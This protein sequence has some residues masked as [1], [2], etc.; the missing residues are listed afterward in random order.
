[1]CAA[2][3][4]CAAQ[5]TVGRRG[6]RARDRG[7]ATASA[8]DAALGRAAGGGE[9]GAA[10]AP[11]TEP[12]AV[13]A[14]PPDGDPVA[15]AGGDRPSNGGIG[16]LVY[17]RVP[18]ATAVRHW[19]SHVQPSSR[20]LRPPLWPSSSRR[21]WPSRR[22]ACCPPPARA[23]PARA[24]PIRSTS[25]GCAPTSRSSPR[26]SS[27]AATRRRAASTWR[28]A[29]WPPALQALGL[30][31]AG[32]DGGYFQRFGTTRRTVDPAK[33]TVTLGDRTFA[34]RRRLPGHGAGHRRGAAG[35]RRPR[36]RREEEGHRRLWRR[37]RE[38]QDPRRP[39]RAIRRASPAPTCAASPGPTRG[40]ARPA[41]PPGTAPSA[42]CSCPTT[43]R[44]P[45]GAPAATT[46]PRRA[47]S[48]TVDA[49]QAGR[50][51]PVPVI[52]ASMPLVSAI[53]SG[54]SISASD[55]AKWAQEHKAHAV[56]ALDEK[57][58][59]R[60]D[61]GAR[62]EAVHD[63]ERR[64]HLRGRRPGAQAGV[65]RARRPLRPHR[66][67]DVRHRPHQQ[68]RR[69]RRLG[70]RRAAE[71]RR[72]AGPRQRADEAVVAVR[73]ARRRRDGA[74]GARATSSS[75]RPCRSTR[76]SSQLNVDMIGRSR[77]PGDPAAPTTRSPA[78][79]RST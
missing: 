23:P 5:S 63:A 29:T 22:P 78:R 21:A 56:V 32:D 12:G 8:T 79:T 30:K 4:P 35:L 68:R 49:F 38:G 54:E 65:R 37:R 58:R 7:A 66:R 69:R 25:A 62:I 24:A 16:P 70:H 31:P 73:L 55:V 67:V 61:L 2:L 20:R 13:P 26:T 10:R 34:L 11:V 44:W 47:A 18:A 27:K 50:P 59:L 1:M 14:A 42:S 33:A 52:T 15:T 74:C 39:R 71:H 64:R 53:F 46:P 9:P 77:K 28:P 17:A 48:L 60:L 41:T 6:G 36:P 76:S 72:G 3:A 57:K 19:T 40:R 51:A 75:T 45:A 43:R